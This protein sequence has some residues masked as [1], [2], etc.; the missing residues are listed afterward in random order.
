[1]TNEELT[2]I[3]MEMI[4]NTGMGRNLTYEAI[5]L[6][7]NNKFEE[8]IAKLNEAEK[9][10][11]EA[12]KL[13]FEKIMSKQFNGDSIFYFYTKWILPWLQTLKSICF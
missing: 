11:G 6:F 12:H 7:V 10:I 4:S 9:Y 1:M 5:E 3:C 13:Q 2:S 8:C